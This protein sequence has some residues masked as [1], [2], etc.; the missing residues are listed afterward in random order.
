M[1]SLLQ[2]ALIEPLAR[3]DSPAG[4][5][6]RTAPVLARLELE[7]VGVLGATRARL[8]RPQRRGS[9]EETGFLGEELSD[10]V[11]LDE[12]LKD[13][14]L[15]LHVVGMTQ[16]HFLVLVVPLVG[17]DALPPPKDQVYEEAVCADG[18]N[19]DDD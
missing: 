1:C 6:R 19:G 13:L 10:A 4:S 14:L 2:L 9:F 17:S 8:V 12:R 18:E 3:P 11:S 15:I 16:D 7:N 5:R